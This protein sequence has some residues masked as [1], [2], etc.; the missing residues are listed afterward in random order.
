[1]NGGAAVL[2]GRRHGGSLTDVGSLNDVLYVEPVGPFLV[3]LL[4]CVVLATAAFGPRLVAVF[5]PYDGEP[6]R[7]G[8]P[9]SRWPSGRRPQR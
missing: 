3:G 9:A 8:G 2:G 1:L 4:A 5:E 6:V 7:R